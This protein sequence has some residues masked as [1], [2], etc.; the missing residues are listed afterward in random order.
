MHPKF[1]VILSETSGMNHHDGVILSQ[2]KEMNHH[3]TVILSE[4]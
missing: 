4:A 2:A 1:T 3:N